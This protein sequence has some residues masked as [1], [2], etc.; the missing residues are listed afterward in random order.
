MVNGSFLIAERILFSPLLLLA[1][2]SLAGGFL[3]SLK[4]LSFLTSARRDDSPGP[5]KVKVLPS[6]DDAAPLADPF[7]TLPS[8]YRRYFV[9]ARR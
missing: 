3:F 4:A 8:A 7:N 2:G 5:W 6:R 9:L 1:L